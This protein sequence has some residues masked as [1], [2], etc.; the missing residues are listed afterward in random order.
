[1][2]VHYFNQ[3]KPDSDDML[4]KIAIERGYVP[5]TCLLGGVVVMTEINLSHDPC[6]GCNCDR[7]KCKGREKDL[8]DN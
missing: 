4:L 2:Q 8:G 7:A 1:M 5:D 6:K 3:D